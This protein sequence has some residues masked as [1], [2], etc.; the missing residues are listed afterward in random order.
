MLHNIAVD[1]CSYVQ[2]EVWTYGSREIHDPAHT[3]WRKGRVT[4]SGTGM[5][6][7]AANER[8]IS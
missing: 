1:V 5:I 7:G 8:H 6:V 3:N 4:R 2:M